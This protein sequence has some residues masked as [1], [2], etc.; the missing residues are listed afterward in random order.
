MTLETTITHSLQKNYNRTS[1]DTTMQLLQ[2]DAVHQLWL[3]A[4]LGEDQLWLAL[5]A[6][7]NRNITSLFVSVLFTYEYLYHN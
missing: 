2:V 1:Y 4:H 3:V 7:T 5:Q 6:V